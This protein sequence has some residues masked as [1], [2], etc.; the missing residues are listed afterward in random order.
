MRSTRWNNCRR[1]NAGSSSVLVQ[2]RE[3][4][5]RLVCAT[6]ELD[7][8][9]IAP[10][11][12]SITS[13]LRSKKEWVWDWLSFGQLSK[14][15]EAQ[16]QRRTRPIAARAWSSVCRQLVATFKRARLPHDRTD[17]SGSEGS[18]CCG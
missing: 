12:C 6:L 4:W 7:C 13:L 15:T 16:S 3:M 8:R 14:L 1:Q 9:R 2:I 11:K 17:A 10:T 5:L 18:L